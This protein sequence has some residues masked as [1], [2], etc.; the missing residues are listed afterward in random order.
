[1]SLLANEASSPHLT[2][3]GCDAVN[4]RPGHAAAA[5][6]AG[7]RW[8]VERTNGRL[9]HAAS[10]GSSTSGCR[11][12][13]R[14]RRREWPELVAPDSR[15]EARSDHRAGLVNRFCPSLRDSRF[16]MELTG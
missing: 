2:L 9:T 1:V 14:R 3:L 8:V 11:S 15:R 6:Q 12:S 10:R 5:R 4:Q 13:V 7:A 16:G